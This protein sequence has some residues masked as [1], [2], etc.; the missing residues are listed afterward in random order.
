MFFAPTTATG[1]IRGAR[2]TG[3]QEDGNNAIGLKFYT[4]LGA[5][6]TEKMRITSAGNVGIGTTSPANL[7]EVYS[8]AG[9]SNLTALRLTNGTGAG[10]ANVEIF[11]SAAGNNGGV[12]LRGEAPGS[13][14]NNFGVYVTNAGT[15]QTT[16]A[17]F[18]QGSNNN[19]GIGTTS[20]G[21]NLTVVRDANNSSYITTFSNINAG[22]SAST[23]SEWSVN[24]HSSFV[25]AKNNG[26]G[27][28]EIAQLDNNYIYF[29][30]NGINVMSIDTNQNVI[31]NGTTAE[32]SAQLEVKSTTK[33]FLPPRMDD[34]E[35]DNISSPAEGLMI[36]NT[37]QRTINFYDGTTWQRVAVV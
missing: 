33:G 12:R 27:G 20:P 9:V 14:H 15:L 1:N 7:L 26:D 21:S 3:I 4:G 18:A 17:I 11:L 28:V 29:I 25:I 30:N 37:T 31:V 19:V 5:S 2:I 32:A 6:I 13:N 16:P 34:T 22:T 24:G 23:I 36:Y 10:G 35:R 8:A